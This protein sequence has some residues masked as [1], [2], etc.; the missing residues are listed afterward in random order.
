VKQTKLVGAIYVENN[1]TP[2]AFT[3]DRVAVLE[4]LASQAATSLEN[5]SLYSNLHRSEPFLAQGQSISQT[6][7]FGWSVVSGEIYWS[8]ETHHIFELD[9]SVQPTIEFIFQRFHPDDIVCG[10]PSTARSTKT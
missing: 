9:R 10:R 7:S 8:E 3:S 6:G 4:L 5:A 2:R 1:L